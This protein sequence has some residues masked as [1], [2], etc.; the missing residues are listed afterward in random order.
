MQGFNMGRYVP[1]DV[2]GTT[3]GNKLH[4]KHALGARA[5]KL[6]THGALTVRFEMPF[7]VWCGTCAAPTLIAQGVRFNA[8]KR[9]V[10]HYHSTPVFS[11]RLRHPDC[12][13]TIEIR[14]DPA[15]TAY[16]VVEGGRRRDTGQDDDD[17]VSA[18]RDHTIRTDA[19]HASLRASAFARLEKTIADRAAVE[20]ARDR[21]HALEEASARRWEDPYARNRRLRDA[22]RAGRKRREGEA[23]GAEE[24]AER[25]GLG[26]EILPGTEEDARRAALVDFGAR[27]G[28]GEVVDS[29]LVKP[30]QFGPAERRK[31]QEQGL[32]G[33]DNPKEALPSSRRG[34][35]VDKLKTQ[36]KTKTGD[37]NATSGGGSGKNKRLKSEIA[38]A[39]TRENL[40]S[41]L[42]GN[43][44]AAQDPFLAFSSPPPPASSSSSPSS[45][46]KTSSAATATTTTTTTTA[47]STV[48][49]PGIK[50][51]RKEEEEGYVP[52]KTAAEGGQG[53]G[54][55]QERE[56]G[57][58]GEK[59]MEVDMEKEPGKR[60]AAKEEP[61]TTIPP[62]KRTAGIGAL[63][64]PPSLPSLAREAAPSSSVSSSSSS[65]STTAL[66]VEYD[67]D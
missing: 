27:E 38:A 14:T 34:G 44:R 62:P 24:L 36:T 2:E 67:S 20:G 31:P 5:S 48:R 25:M 41:V 65:S 53:Q 60:A 9:R 1:P 29:A 17:D 30:L 4:G 49:I 7:G 23:R 43:A 28:P 54:R 12:G 22:F 47:A 52:V 21:I 33:R 66:L 35:D 51:K 37:G 18:V 59:E 39:R 6:R 45:L 15:N 16:V 40:V 8:E 50:R 56:G 26:F 46:L 32:P 55:G 58:I 13:G 10:G 61:E 11:F 3:S 19:E 64:P 42:V 57:G 63:P